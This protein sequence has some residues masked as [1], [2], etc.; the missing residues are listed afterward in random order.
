[1]LQVS[2]LSL[3][4]GRA[5]GKK[6]IPILKGVS[7]TFVPGTASLLVGRSGSGKTSLLR[8]IAQLEREYRGEIQCGGRSLKG[9]APQR[10]CELIGFVAQ[11][12][13]LFPHMSVA[14]NCAQPL[15]L[16]GLT[17]V[18]AYKRVDSLLE[19]LEIASLLQALPHEISGG[20]RQ[21]VAIARALILEPRFLLLDEPTSALD[22]ASMEALST[23]L[24]KI[25]VQG[26]GLIIATHDRTFAP[27]A[28]QVL[29]MDQ[30]ELSLLPA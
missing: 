1:M 30:G 4:K 5:R 27:W 7:C 21:R 12:Y 24:Q 26:T 14:E 29:D 18:E 17:R 6:S 10:R 3:S 22:H 2:D 23:L 8:C 28:T 15:I 16:R 11:S 20:Q 19:S 25:L 9:M 13:P